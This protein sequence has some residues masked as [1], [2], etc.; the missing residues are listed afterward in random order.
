VQAV[1]GVLTVGLVGVVA[2]QLFDRRVCLTAMIITAVDPSLLILGGTL[3]TESLFVP[4]ELGA[5]AAALAYRKNN[6]VR[7]G[8]LAGALAGV[9]TLTRPVGLVLVPVVA[10][11]IVRRPRK[12]KGWRKPAIAVVIAAVVIAPW[13][14]RNQLVFHKFVPLTTIDGVNLAGTYNDT[15]RLDTRLTGAFRV[16]P[17]RPP[18]SAILHNKSLD[19]IDF[20]VALRNVALHYIRQHKKYAIEVVALNTLRLAEVRDPGL[21]QGAVRAIGYGNRAA[22]AER[23]VWYVI[24]ALAIVGLLTDRVRRVP[25]AVW[26]TPVLA[27]A[28]TV[29]V[30]GDMR[31]RAP[32]EPFAILLA[33]S[34]AVAIIDRLS[35]GGERAADSADRD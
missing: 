20:S 29:P 9:A 31:Y 28:I 23:F 10:L 13:M 19:E 3:L 18:Y 5:V 25:L 6:D 24:F 12:L 16:V 22:D 15:S 32:I 30:L 26:L 4:L 2:R 14:I 21:S 8:Y 35:R 7:F 27:W 33:A 1:I 11:L 17:D 34:G